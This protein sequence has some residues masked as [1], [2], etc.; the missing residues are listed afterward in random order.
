[1]SLSL[2]HDQPISQA[3]KSDSKASIAEW[4]ACDGKWNSQTIIPVVVILKRAR[5][6][7]RFELV[8]S[9]TPVRFILDFVQDGINE[10]NSN[11]QVT[12]RGPLLLHNCIHRLTGQLLD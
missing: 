9:L 1:M 5:F 2:Y 8:H 10:F 7:G 3:Q 12:F 4:I 6:L 11:W